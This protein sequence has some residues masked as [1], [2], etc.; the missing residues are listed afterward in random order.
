MFEGD[1]AALLPL[2]APVRVVLANIISSVLVELLPAI[3]AALAPT[4]QR[5]S[6]ASCSEERDEML[7]VLAG[8]GWRVPPKMRRTSGGARV[9]RAARSSSAV[10]RRRDVRRGRAARG[11]RH[12]TLGEDAAHHMRVLRLEPGDARDAH[13]TAQG[14]RRPTGA[15][16]RAGQDAGA[17]V[18]LATVSRA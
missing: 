14:T 6:A 5:S 3:D 18:E 9:D 10:A 8:I 7:D 12:V 16:V 17:V 13:V 15:L 1:A 4:A 2:V 11:R